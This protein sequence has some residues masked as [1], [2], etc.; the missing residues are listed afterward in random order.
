MPAGVAMILPGV[1]ACACGGMLAWRAER[2]HPPV[3]GGDV[4]GTP[5]SA[6]KMP[7]LPFSIEAGV[8]D[9][10]DSPSAAGH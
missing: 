8:N 10:P 9:D 7:T 4:G 5:N 2:P 6:G 3:V 1:E